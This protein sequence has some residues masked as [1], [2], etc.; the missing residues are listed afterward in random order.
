MLVIFVKGIEEEN[1]HNFQDAKIV[2]HPFLDQLELDKL[3]RKNGEARL[4]SKVLD[5]SLL[6]DKARQPYKPKHKPKKPRG[7]YEDENV[8]QFIQTIDTNN[9]QKAVDD[10]TYDKHHPLDEYYMYSGSGAK[11]PCDENIMYIINPREIYAPLSQ[12]IVYICF[13]LENI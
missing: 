12:I 13:N 8:I 2:N 1:L 11:P 4:L 9:L 10:L 3:P 7:K 5:F 6:F